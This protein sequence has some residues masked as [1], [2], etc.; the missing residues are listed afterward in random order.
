MGAH[1]RVLTAR[2]QSYHPM[3]TEDLPQKAKYITDLMFPAKMAEGLDHSIENS[4]PKLIGN[5]TW[6]IDAKSRDR[7]GWWAD[8]SDI[9]HGD[10]IGQTISMGYV[11]PPDIVDPLR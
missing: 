2:F 7:I 4:Q 1:T 11:L 6:G 5:V 8:L 9:D 10:G 3:D